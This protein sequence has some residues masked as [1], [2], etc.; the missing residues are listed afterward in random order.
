M[1][2]ALHS[3]VLA[4]VLGGP[5]AE[6]PTALL[7]P[8]PAPAF[9]NLLQLL[10]TGF[11]TSHQQTDLDSLNNVANLLGIP[12]VTWDIN[13]DDT[14]ICNQEPAEKIKMDR[15]KKNSEKRETI[16]KVEYEL[17]M[18]KENFDQNYIHTSANSLEDSV[19][20]AREKRKLY[21]KRY[22]ELAK[23]RLRCRDCNRT[24]THGATLRRHR[25]DRVC[26]RRLENGRKLE[27]LMQRA[28]QMSQQANTE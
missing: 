28:V 10:T 23:L 4:D 20:D 5:G 17:E 13:V 11:I 15:V 6:S 24:F 14:R 25:A 12:I 16:I 22:Y 26:E 2:L 19:P 27:S 1:L 7:L 8:A 9:T 3:P 18:M 21:Q